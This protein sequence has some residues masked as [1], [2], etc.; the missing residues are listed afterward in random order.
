[1]VNDLLRKA[2]EYDVETI[3]S[4]ITNHLPMVL[5]AL[6]ELGA[7][8]DRMNE[9]YDAYC[10]KL[11]PLKRSV[12]SNSFDW[13]L[14]L[15]KKESFSEYLEFYLIQISS[16]GFESAIRTYI[17]VLLQGCAAAAFHGLIRLSY[18][19]SACNY[20]EVAFGLAHMSSHYEPIPK[21]RELNSSASEIINNALEE[22][23][24]YSAEGNSITERLSK[25]SKHPL[26]INVNYHPS[27][28]T[29]GE[30][31]NLF[32]DLYLQTNDF[33][34]L[35]TITSCHAMRL[36][37]PYVTDCDAAIRAYW[38]SIIS[39]ILSVK[40]LTF[41]KFH[42]YDLTPVENLNL[43]SIINSNNDHVIKLAH[44]CIEEYKH[45][46]NLNTL[47]VLNFVFNQSKMKT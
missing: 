41:D 38:S 5:I 15:G 35:H 43:S 42:N 3:V 14:N 30:L 8:I 39:A 26:F 6:D 47:K 44:T 10:N 22:F 21:S 34:V 27:S 18:G 45:Y 7:P 4:G 40:K 37:L 13:R 9:F 25:I 36:V 23:L 11:Q 2:Q 28:L 32:S 24:G 31:N 33:T 19:V 12:L 16:H 17:D 1:M 20:T 29:L 46:E